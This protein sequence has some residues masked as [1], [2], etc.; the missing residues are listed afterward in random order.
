P[1]MFKRNPAHVA[2][3]GTVTRGDHIIVG[4]LLLQH[5]PHCTYIIL[6]MTPVALRVDIAEAQ[7]LC[8]SEFDSRDA[9]RDLA[10]HEFSAAQRTLVI[11][12]NARRG[13]ETKALAIIHCDPV[14]I[15][16]GHGIRRT[17]IERRRLRLFRLLNL[18]EHLRRRSLVKAGVRLKDAQGLE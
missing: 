11:E 16:F 4:N 15:E 14:T 5:R 17:W 1:D 2:D 18:S 7:F 10:S 3:G 12:K 9:I 8:Q 13:M 6:G